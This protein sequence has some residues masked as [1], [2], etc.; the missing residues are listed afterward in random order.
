MG[1]VANITDL[2][3]RSGQNDRVSKDGLMRAQ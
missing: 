1:R 2:I 3:L